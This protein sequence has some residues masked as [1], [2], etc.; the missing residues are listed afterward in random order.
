MDALLLLAGITGTD[1]LIGAT[2]V[3][4]AVSVATYVGVQS[5]HH[6]DETR[7]K[8]RERDAVHGYEERG[9]V[10][11]PGVIDKVDGWD[12]N[13]GHHAGLS[14]WRAEVDEWRENHDRRLNR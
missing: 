8:W 10:W 13:T 14:E 12:D 9:G 6:A 11:H 2:I 1:F 4:A 5:R 7:S 3:A